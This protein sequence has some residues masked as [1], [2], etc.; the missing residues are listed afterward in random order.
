MGAF[1]YQKH[2]RKTIK[3]LQYYLNVC[4]YLGEDMTPEQA[5]KLMDQAKQNLSI[6]DIDR[7]KNSVGLTGPFITEISQYNAEMGGLNRY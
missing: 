7:L 5:Q 6:N 1:S 2:K 3:N 4:D